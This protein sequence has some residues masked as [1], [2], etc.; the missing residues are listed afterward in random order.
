MVYW[1]MLPACIVIAATAMATGISGTAMLTPF[2]ILAFPLLSVPLLTT[3]QAIGMALFTE[4]FGFIS[5]VIGYHQKKLIDYR[6]AKKLLMVSIPTIIIFSLV[7]QYVPGLLMKIIYGIM[8]LGLAIYLGISAP[9]TVRNPKIKV[10]P[11]MV[12]RAPKQGT[13][14]ER[15]LTASDGKKYQYEFCDQ[16]SGKLMTGIGA[17]MEGLI[18]VGLGEFEMPHLVKQCK[19]PVAISAGISVFVIAVTVLA[20]SMTAIATLIKNEGV[21]SIPWNLIVYTIPGAVIGGQ[22]GSRYQGR[23]S[24]ETMERFISVLFFFIGIAFLFTSLQ[25]IRH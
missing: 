3:G 22:I 15:V 20:G 23:L 25:A 5:G 18:S 1:F 19:I 4:F 11:E 2:L 21:H 16:M 8:M 12:K 17:A 24:S 14:E 6:A 7:S 10:L 9:G 13:C